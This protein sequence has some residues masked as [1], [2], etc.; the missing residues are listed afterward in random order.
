MSK[1][2]ALGL[3]SLAGLFL[4]AAYLGGIASAVIPPSLAVTLGWRVALGLAGLVSLASALLLALFYRDPSPLPA[5][6]SP[7]TTT[8]RWWKWERRG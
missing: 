1:G 3:V 2:G 8:A 6:G 5:S 4:P 7:S